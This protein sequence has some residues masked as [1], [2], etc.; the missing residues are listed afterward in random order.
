M[1]NKIY[2]GSLFL[3]EFQQKLISVEYQSTINQ[4]VPNFKLILELLNI[5]IIILYAL[6]EKIT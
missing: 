4:E 6:K 5:A 3:S 1:L 2:S